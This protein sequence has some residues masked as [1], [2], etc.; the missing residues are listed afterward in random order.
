MPGHVV[1]ESV[2]RSVQARLLSLVSADG[3]L[4]SH[5]LGSLVKF[6]ALAGL[7]ATMK[8]S[9]IVYLVGLVIEMASVGSLCSDMC[10]SRCPCPF[11]RGDETVSHL[12]DSELAY[13]VMPVQ[14]MV[15]HLTKIRPDA[16][17]W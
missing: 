15:I 8:S 14:M 2:M 10:R 17:W 1:S 4:A 9:D 16:S 11:S 5:D 13:P 7:G 6:L 3:S 12:Q